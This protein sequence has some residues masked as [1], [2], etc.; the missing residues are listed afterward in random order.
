MSHQ[1]EPKVKHERRKRKS[2]LGS[3]FARE[4]PDKDYLPELQSQWGKMN[5]SERVK[6]VIGAILGLALFIGA[7]TIVYLLLSSIFHKERSKVLG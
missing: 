7:L 3:L 1:D 5:S 6:F 2:I 4:E